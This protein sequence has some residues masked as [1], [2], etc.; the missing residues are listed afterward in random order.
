MGAK[1]GERG[2]ATLGKR[3][4][5]SDDDLKWVLDR[6][7]AYIRDA[8]AKNGMVIAALAVIVAVAFPN[9]EFVSAA[10][11]MV[12][13]GGWHLVVIV[14]C[15]LSTL[16]L[17]LAVLG[18]IF[19]RLDLEGRRK[20]VLFYGDIDCYP[21]A[22]AF[23]WDAERADLRE[24]LAGQIYVNSKIAKRKMALNRWSLFFL[25]LFMLLCAV[26]MVI[27]S[28]DRLCTTIIA[29]GRKESTRFLVARWRLSRRI[30]CRRTMS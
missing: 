14:F 29:R 24:E 12:V 20:S 3:A 30:G 7:G 1:K 17:V 27:G 13:D 25:L 15:G 16:L 9:G 8:D 26:V 11:S 19:P 2:E 10:K 5:L 23:L 21:S 22:G 6:T 18:S 28:G 4:G